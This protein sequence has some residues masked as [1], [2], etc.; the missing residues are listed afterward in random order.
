MWGQY[1]YLSLLH[2]LRSPRAEERGVHSPVVALDVAHPYHGGGGF[3]DHDA[4]PFHVILGGVL[5]PD[6]ARATVPV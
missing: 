5:S 4:E 3:G 1:I 2:S 6:I